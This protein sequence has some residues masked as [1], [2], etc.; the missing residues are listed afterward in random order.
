MRLVVD[1][2]RE[3]QKLLDNAGIVRE[4]MLRQLR[5]TLSFRTP[6]HIFPPLSVTSPETRFWIGLRIVGIPYRILSFRELVG[7]TT[8]GSCG[9]ISG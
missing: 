1:T 5:H 9:T 4:A 3:Q 6:V 7:A 8:R 2:F